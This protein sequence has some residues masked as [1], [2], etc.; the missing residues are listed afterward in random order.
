MDRKYQYSDVYMIGRIIVLSVFIV[1]LISGIAK[2]EIL[3]EMVKTGEMEKVKQLLTPENINELA[4]IMERHATPEGTVHLH[5]YK[6][7]KIL[8][9]WYDA[10]FDPMFISEVIDEEKIRHFCEKLSL[11]YKLLTT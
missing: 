8:L 4:H 5:V 7:N 11:E 6:D 10:F 2:A 9:Q 1:M 3:H